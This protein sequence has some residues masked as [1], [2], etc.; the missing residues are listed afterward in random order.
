MEL[1][2]RQ[3]KAISLIA[4]GMSSKDTADVIGIT[5]QTLSTW[6]A[7][8]EFEVALNGLKTEMLNA[9]HDKLRCASTIA[10]DSLTDL[11]KNAKSEETRRKAALDILSALSSAKRCGIGPIRLKELEQ[12]IANQSLV[13]SL[14]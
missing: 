6:R 3:L 10:I 4:S 13:D 7:I 5:P 2:I 1:S 8:P 12:M 14:C 11:S 9:V